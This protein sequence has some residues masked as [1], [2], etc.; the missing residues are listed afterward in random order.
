MNRKEISTYSDFK[1]YKDLNKSDRDFIDI[2]TNQAL[3]MCDD[4]GICR[5]CGEIYGK[6]IHTSTLIN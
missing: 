6:C 4:L 1:T 2:I 5:S 3:N